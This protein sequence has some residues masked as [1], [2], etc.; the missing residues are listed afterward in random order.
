MKKLFLISCCLA[1]AVAAQE[2]ELSAPVKITQRLVY[3]SDAPVDYEARQKALAFKKVCE[4]LKGV[5]DKESADVVADAVYE[6]MIVV[7]VGG[8][9]HRLPD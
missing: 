8:E 3:N 1:A 4:I 6:T 7:H 5:H 2:Q 9:A